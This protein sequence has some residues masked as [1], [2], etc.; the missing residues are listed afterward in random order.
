MTAP[1][2][3]QRPD[4]QLHQPSTQLIPGEPPGLS[5][6]SRLL[7]LGDR[8]REGIGSA[9][10]DVPIGLAHAALCERSAAKSRIEEIGRPPELPGTADKEKVLLLLGLSPILKPPSRCR[11]QLLGRLLSLSPPHSAQKS[12]MLRATGKSR[13]SRLTFMIE[14]QIRKCT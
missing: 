7:G 3:G 12:S 4:L 13:C 6:K 11:E 10:H 1:S 2:R 8:P 5:S 14:R 9:Q